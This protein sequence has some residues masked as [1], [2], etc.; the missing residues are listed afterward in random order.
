MRVL[1]LACGHGRIANA[2]ASRGV[3][4]V[5]LDENE[6]F[7]ERAR[8]VAP[9]D[10]AA[11]EYVRGDMRSLPWRDEF[12]AVVCW[13]TS[14]GYFTDAGNFAVLT[15]AFGALRAGGR[16]L[17]DTQNRDR[18]IAGL[19]RPLEMVVEHPEDDGSLLVDRTEYD[20]ESGRTETART[21]VRAGKVRRTRFS[22]RLFS[23]VELRDWFERAGFTGV[24][25]RSAPN[26]PLTL[27]SPR[28]R[29]I[30]RKPE[31]AGEG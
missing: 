26:T 1:D 15:E 20:V 6:R 30:G 23:F 22:V 14:F 18:L 13:F 12:D 4:V 31:V 24:A 21:V 19:R 11:V 29:V 27:E 3:E 16:L 17:I 8:R 9:G 2:F 10:K 28:M 5:G 25:G 7:L